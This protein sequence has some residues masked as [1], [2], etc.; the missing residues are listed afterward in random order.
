M[1][2]QCVAAGCNNSSSSQYIQSRYMNSTIIWYI[3][4]FCRYNRKSP[5][6]SK[7]DVHV[8]CSKSI[9]YYGVHSRRI[10]ECP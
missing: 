7:L 1:P 10:L 5:E 2:A 3:V 9:Q 6:M 8:S 4:F